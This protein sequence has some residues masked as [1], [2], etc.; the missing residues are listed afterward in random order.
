MDW[1]PQAPFENLPAFWFND[2][3]RYCHQTAKQFSELTRQV[4]E[5]GKFHGENE[6]ETWIWVRQA[7]APIIF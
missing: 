5:M 6:P 7:L 4:Q 3:C 1:G 2:M